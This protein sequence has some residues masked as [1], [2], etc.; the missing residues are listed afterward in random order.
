MLHHVAAVDAKTL[1]VTGTSIWVKRERDRPAKN[2]ILFAMCA[3]NG[4]TGTRA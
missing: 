4:G 2:H 1:K 3:V